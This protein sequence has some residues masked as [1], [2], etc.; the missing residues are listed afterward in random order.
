MGARTLEA[1]LTARL[2]LLGGGVLVAVGTGAFVVTDRALDTGDTA[3]ARGQAVAGRDALQR[4]MAEG[5]ELEAAVQEAASAARAQGARLVM[6]VAG[7]AP[8]PSSSS[9]GQMPSLTAGTCTT[10]PDEGGRPWRACAVGNP[11]QTIVAA[12]PVATHR[13]ALSALS[14]AMTIMVVLALATF[15]LAVRRALRAPLAEL[16]S[17]V[18]WT[19]RIVDSE[20]AL[21]PPPART[22]E[23]Q[24]L[25]TAFD[26]L[27]RRLL[28][29]L[30]RSRANSAH[31]AHELRTPLTSVMV[32]LEAMH[33]ADE[34]SG[35][36]L[37]RVRS[38]LTRL[39]DVIESILVLSDGARDVARDGAIVN[40]ADL[41]RSLAPSGARVE[42]PDEA[43]VEGDERLMSLAA[44]NLMDNAKKYGSGVRTVRVSR[45]G[46]AVKLAVVDAG[47]GLDAGAR[48]RMFERY[49]RGAADGDGRGLGL[50]LV[51][52][53]AERYGGKAEARPGPDGVGLEVA[54][55][56][57][58]AVGWNEYE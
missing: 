54:M 22:R 32:E 26:A 34:S 31:I 58:R 4:E 40:V 30:A 16:G 35:Q 33:V 8:S 50:A 21:E 29:A 5:D 6:R 43:L 28:D 55:T 17:L 11:E 3:A 9:E 20:K 51:R 2:L 46:A 1:R 18:H 47:P 42:A 13:A 25:Q 27:V 45:E 37:A 39:A 44:R 57:G 41:A 14:R 12:I 24:R 53:V 52:A 10:F 15:W 23:V 56:L 19:E 7:H 48:E 49:W 38:D 36:A